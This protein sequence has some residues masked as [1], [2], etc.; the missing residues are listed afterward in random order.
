LNERPG[1]SQTGEIRKPCDHST[2]NQSLSE[3]KLIAEVVSRIKEGGCDIFLKLEAIP[4]RP[5]DCE[6]TILGESGMVK[7]LPYR[8]RAGLYLK[9]PM[10]SSWSSQYYPGD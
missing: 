4:I 10:L 9:M 5:C 1:R 3:S 7:T 8:E 6:Y 2:I